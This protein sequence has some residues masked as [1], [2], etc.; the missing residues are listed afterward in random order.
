MP[1]LI[2][3]TSGTGRREALDGMTLYLEDQGHGYPVLLLHGGIMDHQSWGNQISEFAQYFRVLAPDTRGHGRSTDSVEPFSYSLFAED[4]VQLLQR[5]GIGETHVV[6]FSD[7]ACTGM[8][9][10]MR[11]PSIVKNLVVIGTTYNVARYPP[12]T[13]EQFASLTPKLLYDSVPAAFAEV[14]RKA[15]RLYPDLKSWNAFF[16]K[17]V[18]DMWTREPAFTLEQLSSIS[19]PTLIL[20]AENE[21]YYS[22]DDARQMANAIP[23][24]ELAVIPGAGHTSPQE[25]SSV[26]NGSV[27]RF[28]GVPSTA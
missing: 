28:L 26:V 8:V 6:G 13:T 15:R 24:G 9:L 25:N 7:G 12:G 23:E 2:A 27:L 22:L 19:A 16:H 20:F 18:Q 21:P 10:A 17:L 4:V 3:P 5:L 11:Y 1:D 14:M